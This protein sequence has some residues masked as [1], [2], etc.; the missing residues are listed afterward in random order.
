[1]KLESCVQSRMGLFVSCNGG[2]ECEGVGCS[3]SVVD[4]MCPKCKSKMS[5]RGG[6]AGWIKYDCFGCSTLKELR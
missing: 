1:M 2:E 4:I 3:V 6:G 5:I